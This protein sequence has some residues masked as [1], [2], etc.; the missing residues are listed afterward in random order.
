MGEPVGSRRPGWHI[1][2]SDVVPMAGDQIDVHH[3]GEDLFPH[4]ENEIAQS[5][6]RAERRRLW[7]LIHHAFLNLEGKNVKSLGN[8]VSAPRFPT[9]YSGEIARY[10]LLSVHHRVP[11]TIATRWSNKPQL[12][13]ADLAKARLSL[14]RRPRVRGRPNGGIWGQF[15]ADCEKATQTSRRT[16]LMI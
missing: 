11:S 4:H 8:I 16:I 10:M 9:Q 5:E 12:S 6:A 15:L 13:R 7:M 2:C 1:E 14:C 3:G